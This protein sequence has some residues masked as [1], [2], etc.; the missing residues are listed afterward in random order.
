[1]WIVPYILPCNI[2]LFIQG[3]NHRG[4]GVRKGPGGDSLHW[5]LFS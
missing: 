1:M 4:Q 5:I 2:F 3:I